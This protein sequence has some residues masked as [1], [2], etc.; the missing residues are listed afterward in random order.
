MEKKLREQAISLFVDKYGKT[1]KE[2]GLKEID[3][4]EEK[5]MFLYGPTSEAIKG[6]K[7]VQ[8]IIKFIMLWY[9]W[10]LVI[11][12]VFFMFGLPYIASGE[13]NHPL[14]VFPILFIILWALFYLVL[15]HK[16]WKGD[17]VSRKNVVW[18]HY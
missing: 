10:P 16:A 14:V 7:T 3:V 4:F 1:P 5:G 15:W 12:F 9:F 8:N 17:K 11:A 18:I 6:F 13:Y 2:C